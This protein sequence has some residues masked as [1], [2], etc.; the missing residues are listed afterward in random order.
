MAAAAPDLQRAGVEDEVVVRIQVG[1][2]VLRKVVGLHR[3]APVWGRLECGLD[4][5]VPD[6]DQ[7]LR[8]LQ[9]AHVGDVVG[10]PSLRHQNLGRQGV[11]AH[12]WLQPSQFGGHVFEQHLCEAG[13]RRLCLHSVQTRAG[14]LGVPARAPARSPAPW[15]VDPIEGP[16]FASA[17]GFRVLLLVHLFLECRQPPRK[18]CMFV[19]KPSGRVLMLTMFSITAAMSCF[20]T[21]R[22]SFVAKGLRRRC[23]MISIWPIVV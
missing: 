10:L 12:K 21:L 20:M 13:P 11:V 23:I 22:S 18:D 6:L 8:E 1:G 17:R 3:L 2:H 15:L 9:V 7:V 4:L 14:V 5:L 19:P 16:T